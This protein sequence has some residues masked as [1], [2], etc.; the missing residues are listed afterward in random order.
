M[1]A[2]PNASA[3]AAARA[4]N[5]C[6]SS[7]RTATEATAAIESTRHLT[8]SH[9]QRVVGTMEAS[10]AFAFCTFILSEGLSTCGK[11]SGTR[12]STI[13]AS[14]SSA[15]TAACLVSLASAH[16]FASGSRD[17]ATKSG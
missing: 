15:A 8:L 2:G 14:K 17:A 10:L 7:T 13:L 1:L 9:N 5:V 6:A 4:L 12:E 11:K 16:P 3:T